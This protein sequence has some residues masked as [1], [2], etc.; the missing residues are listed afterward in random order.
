MLKAQKAEV[1]HWPT[2]APVKWDTRE[3]AFQP[4]TDSSDPRA[5]SVLAVR[6]GERS[7]GLACTLQQCVVRLLF[8]AL[9]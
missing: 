8:A 3:V 5:A 9:R 6:T 1:C 2:S 7:A 4:L